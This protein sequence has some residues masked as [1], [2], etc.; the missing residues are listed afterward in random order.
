MMFVFGEV[1]EPSQETIMLVEDIV[2]AQVIEIVGFF[3]RHI[4]S[5]FLP[6][7]HIIQLT[8]VRMF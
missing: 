7:F 2:R 3:S 6:N 4:H 1:A 5:C 8:T